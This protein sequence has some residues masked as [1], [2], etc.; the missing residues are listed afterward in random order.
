[1]SVIALGFLIIDVIV[2]LGADIANPYLLRQTWN[3]K[4][5]ASIYGQ[6]SSIMFAGG[7]FSIVFF[8]LINPKKRIYLIGVLSFALASIFSAG[9]QQMFQVVVLVFLCITLRS[10]LNTPFRIPKKFKMVFLSALI[11][12]VGYFIFISAN[13]NKDEQ[14]PRTMME[15]FSAIN[16][17]SY[18]DD[19]ILL[20]QNFPTELNALT[21]DLTFYFSHQ[22]HAFAEQL[23]Y[24]DIH[25]FDFKPLPIFSFIERQIDKLFFREETQQERMQRNANRGFIGYLGSTTWKTANISAFR[26]FGYIGAFIL[27]FFHGII[28]R[29]IFSNVMLKPTFM[30][31]NLAVANCLFLFYT[32]MFPL[33]S[34]TIFLFYLIALFVLYLLK[35]KGISL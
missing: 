29:K 23:N 22:T 34:E 7:Y 11:V 25:L 8:F 10:F 4:E 14:D 32:I 13:R 9:R 1:M 20:T 27:I 15:I 26:A 33:I 24:E 19:F 31:I 5:D 6:L 21:A 30:A 16:S 12:M 18:S 17:F 35:K 28:S 3:S 2:I